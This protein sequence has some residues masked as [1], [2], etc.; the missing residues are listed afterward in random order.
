MQLSSPSE[1]EKRQRRIE[2]AGE[3]YMETYCS[4]CLITICVHYGITK[5]VNILYSHVNAHVTDYSVIET[6][7]KKLY[8][9][10]L[11]LSGPRNRRSKQDEG[12]FTKLVRCHHINPNE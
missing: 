4:D 10:V 7:V 2:D 9:S 5:V 11:Q 8:D 3:V 6:P 1:R 12:S